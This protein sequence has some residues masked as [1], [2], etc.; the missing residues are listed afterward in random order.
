MHDFDHHSNELLQDVYDRMPVIQ[1]PSPA[2]HLVDRS[3]GKE[4]ALKEM[5]VSFKTE[6]MTGYEVSSMVNSP[7][8][9]TPAC[10]Q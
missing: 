3:S 2:R 8:K 7:R 5:L 1:S 10:A 9:Y 4:A 6:L